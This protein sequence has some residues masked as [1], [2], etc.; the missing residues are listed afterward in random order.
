MTNGHSGHL[1]RAGLKRLII[2]LTIIFALVHAVYL[3][4]GVRFD[5][6]GLRF[7]P[8]YLD[9]ALLTNRLA[10]SCFYLHHQPPLFNLFLGVVLKLSPENPTPI[11]H[12]AFLLAGLITYLCL[13]FVQVRLGISRLL[14]LILSSLFLISPSFVLY[15]H[16]LFYTFPVAFLLSASALFLSLLLDKPRGWAAW[17]FFGTLLLL[18]ATRSVF[19]LLYFGVVLIGLLVFCARARRAMLLPGL[20]CFLLL[21]SLYF[22]NYVLFGRF[23]VNSYLGMTLWYATGDQLTLEERARLAAAGEVSEL[24]LVDPF[25]GLRRYPPEYTEVE[26]YENVPALRQVMKSTGANNYNH[27]A[28]LGISDQ[29]LKDALRVLKM[30]PRR[31]AI[32]IVKSWFDYFKSSSDHGYLRENKE[33]VSS[34][35][36]AFDRFL[37]GRVEVDLSRITSSPK[38]PGEG[39]RSYIY[40]TLLIGL[41]LV[42]LYALKLGLRRGSGRMERNDRVLVLYLCFNIVYV[43][44]TVNL[45]SSAENN[46]YRYVTDPFYLILA[47][48][49]LQDLVA[50]FKRKRFE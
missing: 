20:V 5:D 11:F 6:S 39:S 16:M 34:F 41:P 14:A 49:F 46:R 48:L 3:M 21:G 15:E 1:D 50:R 23:S 27:L 26:G 25:A 42:L 7:S 33:K 8:Q 40:L 13:F 9:P 43:A 35:N 17:A 30:Y 31:T 10:E 2:Y 37:F 24:A 12:A 47:G 38:G 22:K 4:E 29:Y 45:L 36:Q 19:H 18:C 32:V 28:Y 44:L